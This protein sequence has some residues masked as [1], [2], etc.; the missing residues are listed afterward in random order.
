[1]I[2]KE[3][4]VESVEE[5]IKA[6]Q[7]GADRIELC[8]NLAVGGTTPSYGTI[9]ICRKKIDLPVMVMIRPRGGNFVYS[10][11]E[12]EV[13]REDI[14]MCKKA[15]VDGV[16]FGVLDEDS[17]VN[18]EVM[19]SL[20]KLA[21]PLEV[22]MH[23]AIDECNDPFGSIVPLHQLGI[24][25]ILT[26]GKAVTALEGKDNLIKIMEIAQNSV[27][28][29]VAGKVSSENLSLVNKLIPAKVFHGRAL[30]GSLSD[31]PYKPIEP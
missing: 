28:I 15:G 17:N 31:Q 7:L 4:P 18:F 13:M 2:L 8:E 25:N 26:S 11:T 22:T 6:T 19:E 14:K 23:K 10:D 5:A 30:V 3:I 27:E 24:N 29:I 21:S 20:T 1:M 12:L 9:K 16:V